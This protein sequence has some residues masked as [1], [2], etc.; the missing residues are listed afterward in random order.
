MATAIKLPGDFKEE[1]TS[2]L[3]MK[4]TT[5]RTKI[6]D[7]DGMM[8]PM[9]KKITDSM[10]IM[11]LNKV[12]DMDNEPDTNTYAGEDEE[13]EF[14]NDEVT[15]FHSKRPMKIVRPKSLN[16]YSSHDLW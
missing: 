7:D 6:P 9:G 13:R 8:N 14:A 5:K 1:E 16:R 10:G 3:Q 4:M 15:R 12:M 11:D 2:M